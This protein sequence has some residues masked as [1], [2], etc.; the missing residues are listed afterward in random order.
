MDV[1]FVKTTCG[2]CAAPHRIAVAA[3][4]AEDRLGVAPS[5]GGFRKGARPAK[6]GRFTPKEAR[7]TR[8]AAS[9]RPCRCRLWHAA[10]FASLGRVDAV[11]NRPTQ[12]RRVPVYHILG[13]GPMQGG[14]AVWSLNCLTRAR[15]WAAA[16]PLDGELSRA[17]LG[18]RRRPV[19][20]FHQR[21]QAPPLLPRS[22][23]FLGSLF[24]EGPF[25]GQTQ[26]VGR[27]EQLQRLPNFGRRT[28][29]GFA[30]RCLYALAQLRCCGTYFGDLVPAYG[31][32]SES[33]PGRT[34]RSV[35]GSSAGIGFD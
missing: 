23:H 10:S 26:R 9:R 24:P 22:V 15:A 11:R 16:I 14:E 21:P 29:V 4:C 33:G 13:G 3:C 32:K 25:L 20:R 1:G 12:G 2:A 17:A 34:P 35:Q 8:E 5:D 19:R 28:H 18:L 7:P 27:N 6:A 30:T 31:E